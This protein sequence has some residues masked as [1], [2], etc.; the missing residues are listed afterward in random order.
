MLLLHYSCATTRAE[1]VQSTLQNLLLPPVTVAPTAGEVA[2]DTERT[3]PVRFAAAVG[4]VA[5]VYP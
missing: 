4:S 2:S 1:P 5:T 3:I